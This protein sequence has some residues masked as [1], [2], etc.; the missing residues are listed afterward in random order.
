LQLTQQPQLR[1]FPV[2][3]DGV[4]RDVKCVGGFVEREP[5]EESHL[6]DLTLTHI[7]LGE[8]RQRV[9]KRHEILIR[10]IGH[11]QRFV[12]SDAGCGAATFLVLP[13]ARVI[14]Q[15]VAHHTRGDRQEMRPVLPLNMLSIDEPQ[16]RFVYEGRR[17]QT[18][19]H[20]FARHTTTGDP[21]K[22]PLYKGNQ[23]VERRLVALAPF[24]KQSCGFRRVVGNIVILSPFVGPMDEVVRAWVD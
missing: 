17:L 24:Q 3:L 20:A 21:V 6:H 15:N 22:L 14:H 19:A 13:R 11:E 2:S 1:D 9:V 5:A 23:L 12:K 18:V 8:R 4:S 7:N 16:I 10:L